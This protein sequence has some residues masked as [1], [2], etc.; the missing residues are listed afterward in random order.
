MNKKYN[1]LLIPAGSGMSIAA[2]KA[3]KEDPSIRIVS[4]DA[5]RLSAGLYLS[6]KGYIVPQFTDQSFYKVIKDII[7]KEKIDVIIPALDHILMPF[8][9]RREEFMDIGAKVLISEPETIR[10]TRDKWSTY[11]HLKEIVPI[12][13]SFIN[14]EDIDIDFPL[15][16][17]PRRGSGSIDVYKIDS[18]K[19]LD[20]FYERAPNPIIQE[21][22]EGKEYT[23]DCLADKAGKLLCCIP[24]E[25]IATKAGISVKGK[26]VKN[27]KLER[28]A[29]KISN[30]LNFFGPFF[31]QAK[32]DEQG[33]PKLTEINPRIAGTMSLSSFCGPNLHLLAIKMCMHEKIKIPKIN[34]GL[35]ITRY[36]EDI[37]LDEKDLV[38]KINEPINENDSSS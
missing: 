20:F 3:L 6:H 14:K 18:K 15:L 26:V 2:I 29:E 12:P 1:I 16:I 36:F 19:E 10:V 30:S 22:L 13:K 37:Y 23:I 27:E 31:F 7:K 21:Y 32:E 11:N 4:T 24:R 28:M 9:E 33:I 5:D 25:R 17:K 8:S 35:Y 38:N 34:Y